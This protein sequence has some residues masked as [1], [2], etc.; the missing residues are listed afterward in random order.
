M[1]EK[2]PIAPS[3]YK[4]KSRGT[5]TEDRPGAK[6]VKDGGT[7]RLEGREEEAC[8]KRCITSNNS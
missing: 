2:L 8:L 1:W 5:K 3:K 7:H 6:G 4:K